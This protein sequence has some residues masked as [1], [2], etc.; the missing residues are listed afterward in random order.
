MASKQELAL[1]RI[2]E[3]RTNLALRNYDGR[4]GGT[5]MGYELSG[6]ERAAYERSIDKANAPRDILMGGIADRADYSGQPP[7]MGTGYAAQFDISVV[8]TGQVVTTP[9]PFVLFA[10]Q[11]AESGYVDR[12]APLIPPGGGVTS[13]EVKFGANGNGAAPFDNVQK[14]LRIV[15]N[16]A[17]TPDIIDVTCNMVAYPALLKSMQVD[18]FRASR[19][20][21]FVDAVIGEGQ[22]LNPLIF[23]RVNMYGLSKRNTLSPKSY[24]DPK[25]F[26]Q[27][28]RDVDG[29]FTID[30]ECGISGLV[31]NTLN[32]SVNKA[33][34]VTFSMFIEQLYAQVSGLSPAP[35]A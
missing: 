14:T 32:T 33:G 10:A 18:V 20:R 30:K 17:T 5:G 7:G 31:N 15:Y 35:F 8:R 29:S 26:Q 11:D 25:Q 3:Q 27:L 21:Y 23:E 12:I 2:Q 6:Y 22:Y 16:T 13:F 9:L 19:L 4:N 34:G 1:R 28:V 24:L